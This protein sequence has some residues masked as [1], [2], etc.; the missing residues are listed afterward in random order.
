MDG[1]YI[2]RSMK[3]EKTNDIRAKSG[4]KVNENGGGKQMYREIRMSLKERKR[5]RERERNLNKKIYIKN[6]NIKIKK[7]NIKNK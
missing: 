1:G 5:E 6:Y 7:K 2:K 3:S 4:I